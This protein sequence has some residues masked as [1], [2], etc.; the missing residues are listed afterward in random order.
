MSTHWG[1]QP[2]PLGHPGKNWGKINVP[3]V[4]KM[5]NERMN[6]PNKPGTPRRPPRSEAEAEF[7]RE[8][9]SLP[10]GRLAPGKKTLLDWQPWRKIMV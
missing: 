10:A 1:W 5:G 3:T 7:S 9:I 6:V 2:V 4:T 8:S